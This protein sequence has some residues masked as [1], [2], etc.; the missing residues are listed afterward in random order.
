MGSSASVY[1]QYEWMNDIEKV[2]NKAIEKQLPILGICFGHQFLAHL[3]GGK[4]D[5]LWNT[6]KKRASERFKL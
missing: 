1:D 2:I 3:F 4:V 5:Y 6:T